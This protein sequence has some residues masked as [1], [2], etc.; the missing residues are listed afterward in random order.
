MKTKSYLLTWTPE[1]AAQVR[2]Y[3]ETR[4][5]PITVGNAVCAILEDWFEE[6]ETMKAQNL[7]G[8]E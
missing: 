8:E 6:R 4:D 3:A 1:L 5:P 7:E 2:R